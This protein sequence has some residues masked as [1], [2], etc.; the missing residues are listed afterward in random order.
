MD[1]DVRSLERVFLGARGVGRRDDLVGVRSGRASRLSA[2]AH[3]AAEVH[4]PK[5][6]HLAGAADFECLLEDSEGGVVLYRAEE[7]HGEAD[8]L[9][10]QQPLT[11]VGQC[12]IQYQLC[13]KGLIGHEILR[14]REEQRPASWV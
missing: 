2:A 8:S 4:G 11:S 13:T 7:G 9:V 1:L 6:I 14:L 3:A 5:A 12:Y 10:R